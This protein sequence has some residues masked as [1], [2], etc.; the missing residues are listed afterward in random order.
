M[1][2]LDRQGR[3]PLHYA[4]MSFILLENDVK[5]GRNSEV[6][7]VKLLVNNGADVNARDKHKHT[8][9]H[10]ASKK[11][12]ADVIKVLVDAGADIGAPVTTKRRHRCTKWRSTTTMPTR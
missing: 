10:Y 5:V 12:S 9:L 8:P 2:A 6:D 3:M 7:I 11:A 1:G 4:A